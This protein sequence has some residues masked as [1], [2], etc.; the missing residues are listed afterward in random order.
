[1]TG[2]LASVTGVEEA[3][4]AL[5]GGADIIDLKNPQVGALGAL[6]LPT[7]AATV[8]TIRNMAL[9]SA[10]IGDLTADSGQI[11]GAVQSLQT[12]GVDFI[13]IGLFPD[14][15]SLSSLFDSLANEAS[16]SQIVA[17]LFADWQPDLTLL[18][19]LAATGFRGVMLDTATK[20]GAGLR[21]SLTLNELAAFVQSARQHGL[22][23]GLAG[24]LHADDIS[25]LLTLKPGY[26]GFRSAL[27]SQ[28]NRKQAINTEAVKTIR[29]L[30]N[31]SSQTLERGHVTE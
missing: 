7:I 13:K 27:C 28:Q 1:M 23:S 26:L 20:N 18:P 10:T 12:T 22:V 19:R 9:T 31:A 11:P 2:F 5:T 15:G 16:C 4:I 29:G 6:P 8:K 30:I 25:T 24:Q 17:V 3:V 14:G 21:A